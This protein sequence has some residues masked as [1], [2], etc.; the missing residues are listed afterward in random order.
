MSHS[1]I[2]Q[3]KRNASSTQSEPL[4]KKI[5]TESQLN[6]VNSQQVDQGF[7]VFSN[8]NAQVAQMKTPDEKL[9]EFQS[10][11]YSKKNYSPSTNRGLFDVSLNPKTG[12][13]EIKVN[14]AFNFKDGSAAAFKKV[15]GDTEKWKESE[16]KK[17]KQRYISLIEGRWG[18]QYHFSNP[19]LKGVTVYVDVEIEEVTKDSHYKLNVTKAA[20][21]KN[22]QSSVT[23]KVKGGKALKNVNKHYATLDSN[24]LEWKDLT[25]LKG[26]TEK[27]KGAIHEFGHMIGLGDEYKT[28]TPGITHSALVKSALGKTIKEGNSD[29]IM[30][31]GNSINKQ[32]Y[33]TFLDALNAVTG[34]T[35]WKFKKP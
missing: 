13:L 16:K 2:E 9:K 1:F 23:H 4:Q 34:M 33:V 18:G 3:N 20:P 8:N 14:V 17:W 7:G 19:D 10:K 25:S 32:H 28:K 29:D 27:Q 6:W 30:S 12:R 5:D 31:C 24:D 35:N 11:K 21:G 15:K 22:L 26:V